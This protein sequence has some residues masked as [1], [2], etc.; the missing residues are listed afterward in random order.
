MRLT[1]YAGQRFVR[2]DRTFVNRFDP[3]AISMQKIVARLPLLLG[4]ALRQSV[5][6]KRMQAEPLETNGPGRIE[7]YE[8][9]SHRIRNGKGEVLEESRIGKAF[10]GVVALP[11]GNLLLSHDS[12]N[13]YEYTTG[14]T[15]ERT[16]STSLTRPFGLERMSDGTILIAD[17][18]SLRRFS[19]DGATELLSIANGSIR[20]VKVGPDGNIYYTNDSNLYVRN[21]LGTLLG[22]YGMDS[23][24]AGLDFDTNGLLYVIDG[25]RLEQVDVSNLSNMGSSITRSHGSKTWTTWHW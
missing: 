8:L 7:Q 23:Y 6:S 18:S 25:R 4:G 3:E 14:G 12:G 21:T 10:N 19:A 20:S 9:I 13:V 22:T 5:A 17:N 15:Q 16:F 1:V 2:V 11:N 24:T